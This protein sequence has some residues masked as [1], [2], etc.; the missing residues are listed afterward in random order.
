MTYSALKSDEA[1]LGHADPEC[2][3]DDAAFADLSA[4]AM[5]SYA[6]NSY[7]NEHAFLNDAFADSSFHC[8]CD[9]WLALLPWACRRMDSTLQLYH[10]R[11]LSEAAATDLA[12]SALVVYFDWQPFSFAFLVALEQS[13]LHYL[14][15]L[16]HR[17][18][19]HFLVLMLGL[20]VF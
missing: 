2:S 5:A 9:E 15:R 18:S 3:V 19:F 12:A 8:G 17:Y 4:F 16:Y 14:R 6:V 20:V 11:Y 1:V 13:Y 10:Q 7:A